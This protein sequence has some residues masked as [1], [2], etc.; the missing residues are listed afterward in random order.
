MFWLTLTHQHL[1]RLADATDERPADEAPLEHQRAGGQLERLRRDANDGQP[2]VELEQVEVV[3]QRVL[4]RDRVDD[5]VQGRRVLLSAAWSN[6]RP[7]PGQHA[8]SSLRSVMQ[9][10]SPRVHKASMSLCVEKL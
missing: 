6:S 5:A 3:R 10:T 2:P 1:L 9:S 4:R 7:H 8:R